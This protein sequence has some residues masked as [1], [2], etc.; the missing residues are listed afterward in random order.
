MGLFCGGC[1]LSLVF[2][3]SFIEPLLNS[4]TAVEVL[5]KRYCRRLWLVLELDAEH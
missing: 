3:R 1:F 2:L 4:Q 5:V